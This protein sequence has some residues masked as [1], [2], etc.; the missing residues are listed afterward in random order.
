MQEAT[1]GA[2]ATINHGSRKIVFSPIVPHVAVGS[3]SIDTEEANKNIE[4]G[5]KPC[6]DKERG[7]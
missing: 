3:I 6:N 7:A 4:I 1:A 5:C 2:T